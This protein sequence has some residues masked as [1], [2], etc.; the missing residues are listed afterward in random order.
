M[1]KSVEEFETLRYGPMK[2]YLRA[3]VQ[4]LRGATTKA[5][6]IRIYRQYLG[7]TSRHTPDKWIVKDRLGAEGKEGVVYEV[8]DGTGRQCAMKQFKPA[9]SRKTF[10]REVRMQRL[11]H[12]VGAAP[13]V[14]D[15]IHS[16][17]L[18]LVMEKMDE[19]V[20]ACIRRQGGTLTEQQQVD[21]VRVHDRLDQAGIYHNDPNPL[22]LMCQYLPNGTTRWL[23]IDYGFAK[24]IDPSKHGARPN[25]EAIDWLLNASFQG[26]LKTGVLVERPALLIAAAAS[27]QDMPLVEAPGDDDETRLPQQHASHSWYAGLMALWYGHKDCECNRL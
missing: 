1:D 17:P 8:V 14:V 18:R 12:A 16:T 21:I 11:A 7:T 5:Q 13:E 6:F 20:V 27:V 9:K 2:T 25:R 22:N 3:R 10:D 19:T 24:K 26:L 23:L 15:S 4:T